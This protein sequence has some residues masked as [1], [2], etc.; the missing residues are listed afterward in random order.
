MKSAV[1]GGMI[2]FVTSMNESIFNSV[3]ISTPDA[4]NGK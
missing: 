4:L 1:I 3:V 2:G